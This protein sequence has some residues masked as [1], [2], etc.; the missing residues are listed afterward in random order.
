MEKKGIT[1]DVVLDETPNVYQIPAKISA[2]LTNVPII[3]I[4]SPPKCL[5]ARL[6][7]AKHSQLPTLDDGSYSYPTKLR[8]RG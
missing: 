1:V 8:Y 3:I 6:P 7:H 4:D 2:S 5:L